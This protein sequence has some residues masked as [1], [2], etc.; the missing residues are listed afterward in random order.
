ME[1]RAALES[2]YRAAFAMLRH[3]IELCPNDL[4]IAGDPPRATWRIA[5]HALF[6][7]HYYLMPNHLEFAPWD[8]HVPHG[9]ILWDDDETGLPPD[10]HPYRQVDLIEY[11]DRIVSQLPQWIDA[12]NLESTESG[13]PW[14]PISK[15]EHQL[16]NLRHIGTHTGQF[17]ERLYAVGLEPDWKGRG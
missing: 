13:F 1:V 7:T 16:V 4:W 9:V 12:L 15:L 8:R 6:Y 14:Y 10:E 3:C 11:L 17:Q 5:Y 2:Q